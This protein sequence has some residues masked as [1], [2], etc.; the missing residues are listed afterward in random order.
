MLS[1][2]EIATLRN[3]I[4]RLEKAGENWNDGGIRKRI[5]GWIKEQKQK[6]ESKQSKTLAT[7]N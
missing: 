5:E 1:P 7:M 3:E 2:G 6:V 4:K